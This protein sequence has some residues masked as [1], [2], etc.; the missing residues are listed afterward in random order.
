MAQSW[1]SNHYELLHN[2]NSV[3]Y[4]M[5]GHTLHHKP[6]EAGSLAVSDVINSSM[7]AGPPP[8]T[9][10][11]ACSAAQVQKCLHS[12]NVIVVHHSSCALLSK[13]GQSKGSDP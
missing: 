9:T 8:K 4:N 10:S 11:L 7:C 1:N 2:I 13:T 5:H 3:T 6:D 12:F